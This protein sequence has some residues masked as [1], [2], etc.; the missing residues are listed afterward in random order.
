MFRLTWF[1]EGGMDCVC[2]G[3]KHPEMWTG[4]VDVFIKEIRTY[5]LLLSVSI[6]YLASSELLFFFF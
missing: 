3:R 2:S 5:T 1:A 6:V 4:D